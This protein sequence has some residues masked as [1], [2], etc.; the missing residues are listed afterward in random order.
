[1]F[2]LSA[3]MPRLHYQTAYLSVAPPIL[4]ILLIPDKETI[5]IQE[6]SPNDRCKVLMKM[7]HTY[8]LN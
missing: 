7:T 8:V 6:M 2:K 3:S 4:F 1:M 5:S